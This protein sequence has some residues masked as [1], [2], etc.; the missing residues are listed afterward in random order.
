ME[1]FILNFYNVSFC[2]AF[3]GLAWIH[4]KKKVLKCFSIQASC[5][6]QRQALLTFWLYIVFIVWYECQT[7][8]KR[9]CSF[10]MGYHINISGMVE[11][12]EENGR[13]QQTL[14]A[15]EEGEDL[16]V[17]SCSDKLLLWNV[18]GVQGALY[19]NF[20]EP[21]YVKSIIL[22]KPSNFREDCSWNNFYIHSLPWKACAF[23]L[24]SLEKHA[25]WF[26]Q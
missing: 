16:L 24:L 13:Q 14:Q 21:I 4:K 2:K 3:D 22:G 25:P 17:M 18:V 15:L 23:S 10:K 1:L 11:V 26:K 8:V 6:V 9:W 12:V 5:P 7:N 20:L 19:S